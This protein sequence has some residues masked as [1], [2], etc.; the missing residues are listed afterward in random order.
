MVAHSVFL[1]A[2]LILEVFVIDR[3][4]QLNSSIV[5]KIMELDLFAAAGNHHDNECIS[6]VPDKRCEESR[7]EYCKLTYM[8]NFS[9]DS[10][11][12]LID[13]LVFS[14]RLSGVAN[15]DDFVRDD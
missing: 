14:K 2:C 1:L 6:L 3:F 5:F 15:I 4:D 9:S 10:F 11:M 8:Q 7:A 12:N 13:E